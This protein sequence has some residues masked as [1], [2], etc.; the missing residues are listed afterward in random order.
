MGA[1]TRH[2]NKNIA[3]V[4]E[5]MKTPQ[6]IDGFVLGAKPRRPFTRVLLTAHQ[7]RE[8]YQKKPEPLKTTA[9]LRGKSQSRVLA[10]KY[11]V[12]PK[13]IRDIWNKRSWIHA[14][15]HSSIPNDSCPSNEVLNSNPVLK[16]SPNHH[17]SKYKSFD[18][19]FPHPALKIYII[20]I[21]TLRR[22]RSIVRSEAVP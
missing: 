22:P 17:P 1:F 7:A 2:K 11:G 10:E 12:S 9:S 19:S 21:A 4:D 18:S 15:V 8:I 16:I 5:S 13:T 20:L 3:E 6:A 14:T